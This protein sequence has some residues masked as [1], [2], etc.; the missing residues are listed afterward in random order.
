[1]GF[2][3]LCIGDYTDEEPGPEVTELLSIADAMKDNLFWTDTALGD[4]LYLFHN[5]RTVAAIGLSGPCLEEQLR[6]LKYL[7]AIKADFITDDVLFVPIAKRRRRG[8]RKYWG[9]KPAILQTDNV[10]E[11]VAACR[12]TGLIKKLLDKQQEEWKKKLQDNDNHKQYGHW[13]K[14]KTL[15]EWCDDMLDMLNCGHTHDDY[16][17]VRLQVRQKLHDV[18]YN[19]TLRKWKDDDDAIWKPM[20]E[21]MMR[22][23]QPDLPLPPALDAASS[24]EEDTPISH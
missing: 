2:K 7:E 10:T 8:G 14:P 9:V 23:N 21:E 5:N 19:L 22:R 24:S 4:M 6:H 11:Y 13:F 1:M 16:F 12:I 17:N 3:K 20:Y 18:G 15:L